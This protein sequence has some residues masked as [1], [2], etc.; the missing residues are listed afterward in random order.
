VKSTFGSLANRNYRFYFAGLT[1]SAA[2]TWMQNI[3]IGWLALQSFHSGTILGVVT[4]ARYAPIVLAGLWSGLVVDRLNTR[5]LL[6]TTESAHAALA[7]TLGAIALDGDVRLWV[8]LTVV[9]GIGIVDV[10]DV[11]ARQS[12]IGEIVAGEQLGNAI[13]LT[14]VATNVARAVGPAV[15]GGVIAAAGTATCFFINAG[16][17]AAFIVALIAMRASEMSDAREV[18]AAGQVRAGLRYVRTTPAL[19]AGL[20]MV[21]V[22]GTLTWEYPVALPVLTTGTFGGDAAAY[23]FAMASLGLGAV[24][25]GF[26]AARRT[27]V[28]VRSLA[29]Y[30]AAWGVATLVAAVAPVLG[31]LY[32]LLFTVGICGI[33]F[34]SAARVLLQSA[35]LPAM[36]GRVMSLWFMGW[37]GSTLLGAPLVGFVGK[38]VGG[39][40][41]L[42]LGGVGALLV[43]IV[44]LRSTGTALRAA[45]EI[46]PEPAD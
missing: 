13:G 33:T 26:V 41:A 21:A 9:A 19:M 12:V 14:A 8:L 29:A 40:Y 23:G 39:R 17:F 31:V 43:G 36:R 7:V 2:G 3:A 16:S 34:N 27:V 20:A 28:T 11:P 25:G 15:A 6:V 42:A 38:E 22:T 5:W 45:A 32:V 18:R 4:A 10:L 1:V 37:Q 35:S 46:R 44:F 30:A 24:A